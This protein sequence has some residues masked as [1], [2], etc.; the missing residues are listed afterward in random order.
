MGMGNG[1][2][3]ALWSTPAPTSGALTTGS[4]TL[5]I[6]TP[7]AEN[8]AGSVAVFQADKDGVWSVAQ[9]TSSKVAPTPEPSYA[10]SAAPTQTPTAPTFPPSHAPSLAPTNTP[11][12][13]PAGSSSSSTTS[14]AIYGVVIGGVVAAIVAIVGFYYCYRMKKNE[15]ALNAAASSGLDNND[16]SRQS[17]GDIYKEKIPNSA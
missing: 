7:Y 15:A 6:G 10:P 1:P 9:P 13:A 12:N 11:A 17:M 3:L 4:V 16:F 8:E 14:G 2:V 5:A